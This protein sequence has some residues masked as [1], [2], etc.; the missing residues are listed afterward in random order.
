MPDN[1]L[2]IGV[3]VN[4]GEVGK[5]A[6]ASRQVARST[7]TMGEQFRETGNAATDMAAR[8]LRSGMDVETVKGALVG[9]G[10]TAKQAAAIMVELGVATATTGTEMAAT[11][12]K[13]DAFTRQLANSAIRIAASETGMG[14]L[15]FAF[16]RLGAMS[17]TLAPIL[18]STFT[19]FAVVA[20]VEMIERAVEAYE[21]WVHLGEKTV[22]KIDDQTLSLAMQ[23]DQLDIVNIRIENQIAKLE[24][25]PENFL[26]LALAENKLRAD[27]LAKSLEDAIQKTVT[28]L[29]AGPGLGS[30]MFL[31]TANIAAVGKL[32]E[33]LERELQLAR[34]ANDQQAEKS[35]LLKEQIILQKALA[36]ELSQQ[37]APDTGAGDLGLTGVIG[38]APDPDALNTYKSAL[39]GV[40]NQLDNMARTEKSNADEIKLAAE[41]K[42]AEARRFAEQDDKLYQENIKNSEKLA[43]ADLEAITKRM[44]LEDEAQRRLDIDIKRNEAEGIKAAR[45]AEEAWQRAAEVRI[46]GEEEALRVS[47]HASENRIRD[48][49]AQEG[50][51]AAGISKGP[52]TAVFEQ[53]SLRQQ[54]IVA[55]EA[56]QEAKAAAASYEA[57]LDIVKNVMLEVNQNSEEGVRQFRDLERQMQQLQHLMDNATAS[58]DRWGSTLKQIAAQQR[59]LGISMTNI[60]IATEN[61]AH[62][63]FESFNSAFLRM[64]AGGASFAHVMQ[65]LW[66][67]IANSFI[68]SVLKMAEEWIAKKL[69]M[70]AI[71]RAFGASAAATATASIGLKEVD[72]Q[73][74]IGDAAATAA[75]AAA[76][77]GPE[78]AIAAAAEVEAALQGITAFEKGGLVKAGL[79]EGE[80]VLPAHIASFVLQ[81]ASAAGGV[82][83]PGGPGGP[84]GAAGRTVN[85]N[86]HLEIHH[87]GTIGQGDITNAVKRALRQGSYSV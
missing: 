72:R 11:T 36:E 77:F 4:V 58:A 16:G 26:G 10:S 13:V 54:T 8:F 9:L 60:K 81:S 52:I 50:I 14:Q 2:R 78:A 61:A 71:E 32:I 6:E 66:T 73:A 65:S 82:G 39:Q 23:G 5:L 17:S 70:I 48:I 31:G 41:Q 30:A 76:W 45:Q 84:G 67:G 22:H 25:K 83:G 7:A 62:A 44:K 3:E 74:A 19:V 21:K 49:K 42:A 12:T 80:M 24:H 63:G 86:I 47:E 55:A 85:N 40:Q 68:T 69:I 34:M 87:G 33:P 43:K 75:I 29:K 35:V 57:E 59:D 51:S 28:L 37:V 18:A 1:P 46:R 64:A 56:M 15:G 53:E 20:F 79:H 38:R 27:E